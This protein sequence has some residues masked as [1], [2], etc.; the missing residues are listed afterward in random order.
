MNIDIDNLVKSFQKNVILNSINLKVNSGNIYGI[1]G[2][3]GSGKSTFLKCIAG[4]TSIDSGT[5]S[6]GGSQVSSTS[7]DTRKRTFLMNHEVGMYGSL[8]PSENLQYFGSLYNKTSDLTHE[9]LSSVGLKNQVDREIRFFSAGMLQRLKLAVLLLL[10]PEV[11]LLD[12]P[13]SGLDESGIQL[14]NSFINNWNQEKKTIIIVT[15][16]LKWL[17]KYTNQ[18]GFLIDGSWSEI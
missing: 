12:E 6:I 1:T 8:T 3:N 2:P 13:T 16:D 9:I 5:I 18:V 14:F 7:K 11:V 17:E 15:H 4:L 10:S